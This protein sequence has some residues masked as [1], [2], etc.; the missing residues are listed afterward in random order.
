MFSGDRDRNSFINPWA[1]N[2]PMSSSN[3]GGQGFNSN[4]F[5]SS[6]GS[7]QFGNN[8]LGLGGFGGNQNPNSLVGNS[9]NNG[10]GNVN[11]GFGNNPN[12]GNN[13]FDNNMGGGNNSVFG[14]NSNLGGSNN[15]GNNGGSNAQNDEG[16]ETTQVTIPKD[17]CILYKEVKP[18][19]GQFANSVFRFIFSWLE[20]LSAKLEPAFVESVWNQT[21]SS[22]SMNQHKDQPI[23]S[24]R[25]L[26]RQDKSN[27]RNICY[28]KG[29]TIKRI[30]IQSIYQ[31]NVSLRL[32]YR[33]LINLISKTKYRNC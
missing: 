28:S 15:L 24:L 9:L 13:G 16:R 29:K 17:V 7:N 3:F 22:P 1:S 30:E 2:Q 19:E 5:N 20:R 32:T 27:S 23:A 12:T 14:L 33:V 26:V 10:L 8:S 6:F 18:N 21:L 11:S 31:L 25:F 4:G